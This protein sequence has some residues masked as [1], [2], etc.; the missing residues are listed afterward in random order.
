[1]AQA[2]AGHRAT[3]QACQSG[4]FNIPPDEIPPGESLQQFCEQIVG[5]VQV[6][7]PGFHLTSLHDVYLV[8]NALLIVM[9]WM[10]SSGLSLR[11]RLTD[12]QR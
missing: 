12:L 2:E 7:D 1:M 3:L 10:L 4:R 5:P 6:E 9:L 11:L 8:T